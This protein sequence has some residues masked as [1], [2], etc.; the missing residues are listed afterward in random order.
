MFGRKKKK[1]YDAEKVVPSVRCSVCTGEKVAGFKDRATGKFEEVALISCPK[2][3][4]NFK[5]DYGIREI[6]EEF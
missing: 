2:D 5:R 6:S 4:E 3:L 1:F